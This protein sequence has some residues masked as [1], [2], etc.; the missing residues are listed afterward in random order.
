MRLAMDEQANALNTFGE[1]DLALN[2]DLENSYG[3]ELNYFNI[4]L[5]KYR[6][7]SLYTCVD[8]S[9]VVQHTQHIFLEKPKYWSSC[10][11]ITIR[12]AT[13]FLSMSNLSFDFFTY[14]CIKHWRSHGRYIKWQY[15]DRGIQWTINDR[16]KKKKK[17]K[18]KFY[19]WFD[20]HVSWNDVWLSYSF[21]D[22]LWLE[23]LT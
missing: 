17:K 9:W 8:A 2:P 14:C 12:R 6:W 3:A 16:E 4:R 22:R 11:L 7:S 13:S 20:R 18:R 1:F 10:H 15:L 19:G 23:W 5:H 21:I